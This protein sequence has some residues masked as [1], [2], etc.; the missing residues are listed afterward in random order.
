[1]FIVYVLLLKNINLTT[2]NSMNISIRTV[3]VSSVTPACGA[4]TH[5]HLVRPPAL[6]RTNNVLEMLVVM[7][8]L[9]KVS[10]D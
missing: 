5:H 2:V 6:C 3:P 10:S 1:M 8:N 7:R 4:P 9:G